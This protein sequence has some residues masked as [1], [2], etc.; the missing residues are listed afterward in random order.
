MYIETST[1]RAGDIARLVSPTIT[2]RIF[3]LVV[4]PNLKTKERHQYLFDSSY[5]D[6]L[7]VIYYDKTKSTM[8]ISIITI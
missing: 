1:G 6:K 8:L 4:F 7:K 3:V 5:I 2:V